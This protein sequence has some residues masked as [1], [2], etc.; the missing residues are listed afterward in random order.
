MSCSGVYSRICSRPAI[1]IYGFA[2]PRG[3]LDGD[4]GVRDSSGN[5]NFL[6]YP[7]METIVQAALDQ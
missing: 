6:P 1:W 7:R 3:G 2:K 4:G 5:P